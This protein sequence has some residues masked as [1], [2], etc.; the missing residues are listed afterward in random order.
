MRTIDEQQVDAILSKTFDWVLGFGTEI[1][2]WHVVGPTQN[3]LLNVLRYCATPYASVGDSFMSCSAANDFSTVALIHRRLGKTSADPDEILAQTI[4]YSR[5]DIRPWLLPIPRCPTCNATLRP[6]KPPPDRMSRVY[7]NCP[8]CD[9][10]D[11]RIK[12]WLTYRP[13]FVQAGVFPSVENSVALPLPVP[14]VPA[15]WL[16]EF[17][18]GKVV[19]NVEGTAASQQ[20]TDYLK[21]QQ[22][23]EESQ[24][25][26]S[27]KRAKKRKTR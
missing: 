24:A 23:L 25:G 1:T 7:W 8:R 14:E 11:C 13:L 17:T 3:F 2:P 27:S 5:Y 15:G 9:G 19:M 4:G 26:E 20:V 16:Q 22:K 21:N 10:A 18:P 12:K 6:T